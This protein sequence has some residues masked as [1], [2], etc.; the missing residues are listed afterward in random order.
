M[1]GRLRRWLTAL[2]PGPLKPAK[3]LPKQPPDDPTIYPMF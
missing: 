1:T 2:L 3:P